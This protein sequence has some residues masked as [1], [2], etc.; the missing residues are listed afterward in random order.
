MQCTDSQRQLEMWSGFGETGVIL[1]TFS[2][3]AAQEI[4]MS[5]MQDARQM[6]DDET[7]QFA[8]EVFD[9]ARKGDAQMLERL[10][11]NG[12]P[13]NLR[14]H[15]GDT[16][17]MLASYHGHQEAVRVLLQHQAD[18]EIRND[19]GQ[20]PIA[21]AAFKGDLAVVQLLVEHGAQVEGSAGDGR[22]ALMMAAMF[23]RVA[24]VDYLL[25]HGANPETR[26]AK[27]ITALGAA[28][29]MGANDTAAQLQRLVH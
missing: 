22:T 2:Q 9:V 7:A 20:S 24:I 23:N 26:D 3:A 15:K 14:N 29:A 19:N 10:L 18:P 25:S 13:A 1:H 4:H 16:L 17:L 8:A 5:T 27:G 6:T 12:L 21:G 11:Q 28:Q